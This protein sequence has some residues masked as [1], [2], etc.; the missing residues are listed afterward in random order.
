MQETIPEWCSATI[1]P[2]ATGIVRLELRRTG[3]PRASCCLIS[4]TSKVGYI[5]PC[6]VRHKMHQWPHD[7]LFVLDRFNEMVTLDRLFLRQVCSGIFRLVACSTWKDVY[8]LC[9]AHDINMTHRL[10]KTSVA[11]A[12]ILHPNGYGVTTRS[13]SG[14]NI[15]GHDCISYTGNRTA[16]A[17]CKH[18]SN[19]SVFTWAASHFNS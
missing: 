15:A 12:L 19:R 1:Q 2:S 3:T 13:V 18:V 4:Y 11:S 17:I 14:T 7:M 9:G 16:H 10:P 5:F 8:L 6:V